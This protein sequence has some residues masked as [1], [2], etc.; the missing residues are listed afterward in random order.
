[1]RGMPTELF[2]IVAQSAGRYDRCGLNH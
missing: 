2:N 1:M